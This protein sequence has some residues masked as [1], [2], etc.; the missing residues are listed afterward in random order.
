MIATDRA[1]ESK[2]F[3]ARIFLPR[4]DTYQQCWRE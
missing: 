4:G 3:D 1:R 2:R